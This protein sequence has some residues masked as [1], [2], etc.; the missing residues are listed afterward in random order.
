LQDHVKLQMMPQL[1]TPEFK[2][3]ARR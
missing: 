1:V 3:H 2:T